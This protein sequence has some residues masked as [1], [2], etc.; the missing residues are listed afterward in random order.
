MDVGLILGL[1]KVGLEVYQSETKDK[2]VKQFNKLEK[3]YF[4]EMARPDNERSDLFIDNLLL[5]C[6]QIG[7]IIVSSR[8]ENK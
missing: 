7:R 8:S 2:L 3:E 6:E 5:E 4:D 1:L